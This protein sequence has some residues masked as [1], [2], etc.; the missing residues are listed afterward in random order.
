M[1]GGVPP[2]HLSRAQSSTRLWQLYGEYARMVKSVFQRASF[3][4]DYLFGSVQ[5]YL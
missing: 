2:F 5:P 3:D 4:A 1:G